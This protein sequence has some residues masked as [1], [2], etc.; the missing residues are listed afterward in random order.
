MTKAIP[1]WFVSCLVVALLIIPLFNPVD[2]RI[3]LLG[4][5]YGS[6]GAAWDYFELRQLN[7]QTLRFKL[8]RFASAFSIVPLMVAFQ[9]LGLQTYFVPLI[10]C[11]LAAAAVQY[12]PHLMFRK[13]Y[14]A[15]FDAKARKT[16]ESGV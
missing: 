10:E 16:G 1:L 14:V 8:L 5:L 12:F 7:D 11:L 15:L 2:P 6:F 3:F 4:A 13:R 9:F